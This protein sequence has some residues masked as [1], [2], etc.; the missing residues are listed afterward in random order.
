MKFDPKNLQQTQRDKQYFL[1]VLKKRGCNDIKK[2]LI[3]TVDGNGKAYMQQKGKKY[4][5]F[6]LQW[7]EKLW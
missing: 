5:V 7:Q 1:D 2:V 4:E 3:L 6:N